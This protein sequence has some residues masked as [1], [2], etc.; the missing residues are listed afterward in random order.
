MQAL[1]SINDLSRHR[2]SLRLHLGHKWF[3]HFRCANGFL[4]LYYA[5]FWMKFYLRTWR[6]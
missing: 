3:M 5:F 4:K 6:I 1:E 2:N